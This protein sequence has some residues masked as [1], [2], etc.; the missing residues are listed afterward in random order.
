[1]AVRTGLDVLVSEGWGP[2]LGARTG[3]ITNHTAITADRRHIIDVLLDAGVEL[4]ALFS[5]EHGIRGDHDETFTVASSTDPDT[6][7]PIH[8]LYSSV[9][10]PTA[11]ML[12]GVEL[13]VFDIADVG[14]RYYTYTTTMTYCMEEA[15]REDIRFV[16]LDRPNPITGSRVEGPVLEPAFRKLSAYHPV[17]T[18]HGM[19]SAEL[20]L[21]A[22]AEYEIGCDLQV[23]AC[24]GWSREQWFD[25]TGLP[26]VN[27]SPNL[28]NFNQVMLYSA[29]AGFEASEMS[30]GRGTES[31]FEVFGAPYI[32]AL[33]LARRLNA[34]DDL[35]LRFVPI[36]FMPQAHRFAGERCEGC[37]VFITDRERLRPVE[38]NVRIACELARLYADDIDLGRS[39][40]LLGGPQVPKAIHEGT[41]PD[42]IIAAWQPRLDEYLQRRERY[43]LY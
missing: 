22:N 36:E 12:E 43:L 37:F 33:E 14:V 19:T 18:R 23:V 21:F 27:P 6:G 39:E 31:P 10:R 15:A 13:L 17:P 25:Q 30:V 42:Q 28:R 5:P 41:S 1:M 11:E 4:V 26:W 40:W 9:Q 8:S 32:D 24:Q 3:L 34:L 7:L 35:H 38:A 20:A 16:V 2:L 29:V